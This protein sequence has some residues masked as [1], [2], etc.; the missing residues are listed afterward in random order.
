MIGAA[1]QPN[2]GKPARHRGA[3]MVGLKPGFSRS[4]PL[5]FQLVR[6]LVNLING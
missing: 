6:V 3:I 4:S 1:A 2:A 5:F